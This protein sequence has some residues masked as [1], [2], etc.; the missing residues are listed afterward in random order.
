MEYQ[1]CIQVHAD[2]TAN[3]VRAALPPGLYLLRAPLQFQADIIVPEP[4][5]YLKQICQ[6][7]WAGH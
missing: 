4:E 6:Q 2:I 3:K 5:I 1:T 7:L